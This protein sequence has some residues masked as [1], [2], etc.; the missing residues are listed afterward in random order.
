MIPGRD[1]AHILSAEGIQLNGGR[2]ELDADLN[3]A[4]SGVVVPNLESSH[5]DGR[6]PFGSLWPPASLFRQAFAGDLA[7]LTMTAV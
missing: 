5:G 2:P 3:E 7:V 1:T 6:S 4:G